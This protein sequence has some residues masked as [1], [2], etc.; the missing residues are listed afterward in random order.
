[1]HIDVEDD[2]LGDFDATAIENMP[3]LQEGKNK[4]VSKNTSKMPK[5]L[6]G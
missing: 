4:N 3:D 6:D 5:I 1:M 2:S